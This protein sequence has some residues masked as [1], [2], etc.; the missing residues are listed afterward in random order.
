MVTVT[1]EYYTNTYG[2]SLSDSDFN[3]KLQEAIV[4]TRNATYGRILEINDD[5]ENAQLVD[6]IKRCICSVLD[7]AKEYEET[8]GKVVTSKSSG[9][10]SETYSAS[11]SNTTMKK[12]IAGV[13]ELWLGFYGFTRAVW[14]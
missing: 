6:D 11:S 13:V 10:V 14:L 8:G 9:K 7:K 4:Y 12:D 5:D 1:Y 3:K 2:G